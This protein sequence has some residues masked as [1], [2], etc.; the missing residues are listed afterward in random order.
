MYRLIPLLLLHCTAVW[1][2]TVF[3]SVD[4]H[5]VVTFSDTPPSDGVP[6]ETVEID[7]PPPQDPQAHQERLEALR[8]TTDRMAA[9]R[10]ARERHRAELREIE[11]RTQ[12]YQ[13]PTEPAYEPTVTYVPVYGGP[14]YRDG[15]RPPWRP[16]YRPRP[17]HPVARPPLRPGRPGGDPNDQLMRPIVSPRDAGAGSSNAQLMRPIVSP[18]RD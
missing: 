9:D 15:H 7:T 16:G 13:A 6:V 3:R 11:A 10:M 2:D 18:P 17:D 4:E 8:E 1:A 14:R 5:G 12:A